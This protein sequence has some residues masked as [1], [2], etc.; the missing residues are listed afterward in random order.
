MRFFFL[1][2]NKIFFSIGFFWL[3]GGAFFFPLYVSQSPKGL[4]LENPVEN[5]AIVV[6]TGDRGR[7][8][9]AWSLYCKTSLKMHISGV[10]GK[11][12]RFSHSRITWDYARSTWENILETKKWIRKEGIRS[13][14]LVT[15]DYHMPRCLVLAHFLWQGVNVYPERVRH[16]YDHWES[17]LFKEY[18][19]LIA[20]LGFLVLGNL[21]PEILLSFSDNS[22][23][24]Q[25]GQKAK[26]HGIERCRNAHDF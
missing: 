14:Y 26:Y 25:K 15:S 22:E 13:V 7:L 1:S 12:P 9:A 11:R 10:G 24:H 6:F 17:V 8:E 19:K 18:N 5:S 23:T 4:L 20:S 3:C 16:P 2:L 21:D